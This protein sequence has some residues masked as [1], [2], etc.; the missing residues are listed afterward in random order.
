[1][2]SYNENIIPIPFLS[3]TCAGINFIPLKK[4][5]ALLTSCRLQSPI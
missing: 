5:T 1:M 4:N 3:V 2:L